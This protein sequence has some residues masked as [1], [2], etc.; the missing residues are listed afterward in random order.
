DPGFLKDN[1]IHIHVPAG[2]I[3]KDGPSAGV[4]IFAALVSLLTGVRVRGD[5]AMTGEITLRG[6]VLPVGGI[7][8]KVLAA[9]RAELARVV[10]P[11]RNRKDMEEVPE[12]IRKDLDFVF[13]ETVEDIIPIALEAQ[14]SHAERDDAP[15]APAV[16]PG[17]KPATDG[18]TDGKQQQP[19]SDLPGQ[20]DEPWLHLRQPGKAKRR[21]RT[22]RRSE[23][24]V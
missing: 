14:P 8:E 12:E 5:V 15:S 19:E 17:V 13:I 16:Q 18:G 20:E 24:G 23:Q 4:A 3:P 22:P 9:H 2:A 11:E 10:L 6:S 21:P 7:K 1:D